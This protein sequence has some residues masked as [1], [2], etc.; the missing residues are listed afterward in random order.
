MIG[1]N[2]SS[3]LPTAIVAYHVNRMNQPITGRAAHDVGDAWTT[4]DATEM[5]EIARWGQGYFSIGDNGH[6]KIHPTKEA[7]PVDRSEAAGRSSAASRHQPSDADSLSRHPAAPPERHS[8]RVSGGHHPA[9]IHRQIHLRLSDQ[10]EPAAAGRRG[11]AAI[12][13]SRSTS[14]SKPA[15]SPS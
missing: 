14:G 12:S 3:A 9:R 4:V 10:G 7:G 11:S 6:V 8:R 1:R 15:R 2:Q 5:Y 13:A